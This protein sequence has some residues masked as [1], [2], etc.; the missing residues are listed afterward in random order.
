VIGGGGGGGGRGGGGVARQLISAAWT[1]IAIAAKGNDTTATLL[2]DAVMKEVG[3]VQ[4]PGLTYWEYVGPWVI[5]KSELDG[6][7]LEVRV[8]YIYNIQTN[9]Q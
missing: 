7:P 4:G 5:G 3:A 1:V 2:L 6:D 9:N 8:M